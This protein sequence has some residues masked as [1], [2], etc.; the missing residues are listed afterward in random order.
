M[1]DDEMMMMRRRRI[2]VFIVD[3]NDGNDYHI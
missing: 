2:H 1:I 3:F